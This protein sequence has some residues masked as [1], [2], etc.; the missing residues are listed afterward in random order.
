M[1][2]ELNI[3]I[4]DQLCR[5]FL[6][7][8]FF[9]TSAPTGMLHCHKYSEVHIIKDSSASFWIG[10]RLEHFPACSAFILPPG[11]Y[12]CFAGAQ[13]ELK[14]IA[15]QIEA[16]ADQ[17]RLTALPPSLIDEL[18]SMLPTLRQKTEPRL[19]PL[20]SLICA[21]FFADSTKPIRE[22]TDTS[23]IIYEFISQNYNRD[24]QLSE[25][26]EQLHF[27]SKQT[28][29]LIKRCYSSTFKEA[30]TDYRMTVADFLEKNTSLTGQ[31]ISMRIGFASYSGFWKA[32]KRWQKKKQDHQ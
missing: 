17:Y 3:C 26:A 19:S 14:H 4:N 18:F 31:E 12:H 21:D 5:A 9:D 24:V 30:I 16:R 32:R 23:A 8:G 13:C 11:V 29:R 20:L 10:S 22:M 6:Q 27:S 15:F 25:L 1:N 2:Y 28:E 7:D